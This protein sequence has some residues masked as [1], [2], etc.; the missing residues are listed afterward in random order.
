MSGPRR[1]VLHLVPHTHWDREWY[2]PFQRFR[3]RLVDLVDGV[4]A[5]AEADRRFCFTF[6][7]QTA[8]LDDYLAIRPEAEPRIRALVAAGQLAVGPWRILADELLVAGETLVRNL[9]AGLERAGQLGGALAA[10][11]LPDQFGHAAQVPQLLRRAG[12]GQA[13]L[14]RGVPAAVDRHAFA[15]SAPD[16]STVRTEYLVG[17]YG[18]AADLLDQGD[19]A[20]GS[21]AE[22][23]DRLWRGL[24]PWFGADPVLAMYGTD[25]SSP[26]PELLDLV[27]AVNRAQERVLVRVGTLADY[28]AAVGDGTGGLPGWRGELRSGARANL[29]MGVVSARIGLKAA[30]ARAERLL[31]RYAE[32]L[33]ALHAAAWPAPF[34][35]LAWRR[36]VECSGHDS[37][38]GCG[39]DAVA[40]Q[41]AVRLAEA[42]QLG[43]GLAER[44]A[45][46]VAARVPQGAVA[47]LNPSPFPRAGLVELDL[48]V[49][50]A[51]D[52][53][54]LELP[55]GR[56][57][58]TQE[59][60]RS[61]ALLHTEELPGTRLGEVFRR[62]HGRELFGR[63]VNAVLV[64]PAGRTLT[65]ELDDR[66][67]PLHLDLHRLRR[68]V[69]LAAGTASEGERWQLCV[70][71]PP[72]R[73][74][75][76]AVPAPPLG[77]T[78]VRPRPPGRPAPPPAGA[79]E[80]ARPGHG[81]QQPPR[82]DRATP[83]VR[84]RDGG[85][86]NGLLAVTVAG[87]GSLR[88]RGGVTLDGVGRL[89]DGGDAG[90]LYNYVPPA[91]DQ[92]VIEPD[93]VDVAAVAGGPLQGVLAV[94]RTYR[95]PLESTAAARSAERATVRTVTRVELRAGEPFVRL[96]VSFDNPCRDHRL[97]LHVPLA[98]PAASSFAEGQFAVVERGTTAEG[99]H[100]E[101]P[102]PTFPA[103]GFVDAGGAAVLLDHV[104]EYELLTD[105]PEL[106]LTL[107]RAVGQISRNAHRY[108]EEP[109]GPEVATPGAQCLGPWSVGLAVLPHAGPWHADG[110]LRQ[111]EHYQ[112]ELLA[113]AGTGPGLTLREPAPLPLRG[114]EPPALRGPEAPPAPLAEA[115]G[116]AVEGDG[117]ALSALRRR[118]AW[119]EL[120]LACQHPDPVTATVGGGLLAARDADLLGRPGA[121]LPLTGGA[122]RLE[123][124]AWEI[125]TLLLRLPT[126]R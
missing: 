122:L 87:D 21:L 7:G 86:D 25:H 11:Y 65:F 8:M 98:R 41:V 121:P 13:V 20:P 40:D 72:R 114:P 16:G 34:L 80:A 102:L 79:S 69:D 26:I 115:A 59:T 78:S 35:D 105:P 39:A 126:P 2:Q 28:L 42:S 84:R 120:R 62:V 71:A 64:D 124:G 27:D 22:A 83:P 74:L 46:E 57:L 97:R 75:L 63:V 100:G 50:D 9:E 30:C 103:R 36:L 109:A 53:V 96:R 88:L 73:R 52:Q 110:V 56:L 37:I 101:V 60:G 32:P 51:W 111:A 31:A 68:D 45:A 92:Q 116:L 43:E 48:P 85:L 54:T 89:T 117:V 106:A 24:R 123:L 49:P 82:H 108:R 1:D 29:L 95:W 67:D 112:H 61:A 55:D 107:L 91:D 19:Q 99:G 10:G 14:W 94:E 3:M 113:A 119:L 70:V 58:D 66:A 104:L 90:D 6:D 76:A 23:V 118:G 17:G 81:G 38:T 93:R 15:W 47:V 4:L 33:Q 12:I 77:W 5:R 44:A 125:R 18:N